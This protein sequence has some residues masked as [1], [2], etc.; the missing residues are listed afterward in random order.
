MGIGRA[1]GRRA[2]VGNKRTIVSNATV[3]I[4]SDSILKARRNR[5]A[6]LTEENRTTE[7]GHGK[8]RVFLSLPCSSRASP[9]STKQEEQEKQCDFFQEEITEHPGKGHLIS[10]CA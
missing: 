2:I 1:A 8:S 10:R 4:G 5:V 7:R 6:V 9:S 3:Y